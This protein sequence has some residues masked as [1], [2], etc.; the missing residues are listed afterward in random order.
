[1]FTYVLIIA[2]KGGGHPGAMRKTPGRTLGPDGPG[3]LSGLLGRPGPDRYR[4][5]RGRQG[6]PVKGCLD[7]EYQKASAADG[8]CCGVRWQPPLVPK[9]LAAG[10]MEKCRWW[11][12]MARMR[13]QA[14]G[15][16]TELAEYRQ[17][18]GMAGKGGGTGE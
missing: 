6:R 16:G 5:G 4:R 14:G 18:R 8:E 11:G 10:I 12:G 2:G 15:G 13:K 1:M 3:V 9:G 7:L 17:L